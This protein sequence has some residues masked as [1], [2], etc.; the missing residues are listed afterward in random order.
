MAQNEFFSNI[1]VSFLIILTFYISESKTGLVLFS[2][3]FVLYLHIKYGKIKHLKYFNKIT[4][5]TPSILFLLSTSIPYLMSVDWFNKYPSLN[6][7]INKMDLLL[8]SI[9]TLSAN[10]LKHTEFHL[11]FSST[12]SAQMNLYRYTVVDSGYVQL[13]LV[14]GVLGSILFLCYYTTLIYKISKMDFLGKEKY[15]YLLAILILCLNAFT[16]NSLC[17]LK[18]NFTLLFF[19]LINEERTRLYI[20][21]KLKQLKIKGNHVKIKR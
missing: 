1:L 8:T 2:L 15:F 18:Y 13:F 20:T 11:L 17:S 4:I 7:I 6:A 16:E 19:L 5:I 21:N 10:K 12:N 14:F 3:S 9:L